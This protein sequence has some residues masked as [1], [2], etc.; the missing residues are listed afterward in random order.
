MQIYVQIIILLHRKTRYHA[1][2]IYRW[3]TKNGNYHLSIFVLKSRFGKYRF[4]FYLCLKSFQSYCSLQK[5]ALVMI[6]IQQLVWQSVVGLFHFFLV[7]NLKVP[8]Y[9]HHVRNNL[10]IGYLF[11]TN[12]IWIHIHK[13]LKWNF[14]QQWVSFAEFI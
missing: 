2:K 12:H 6:T 4:P 10:F 7:L 8:F 1:M 11:R 14:R 13:V 5:I 9:I 3:K